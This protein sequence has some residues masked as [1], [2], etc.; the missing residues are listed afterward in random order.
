MTITDVAAVLAVGWLLLLTAYLLHAVAGDAIGR[1]ACRLDVHAMGPRR[2]P[3]LRAYLV[4]CRRGCGHLS[5]RRDRR[6]A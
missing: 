6:A 1:L 5:V 2:I 4:A 3:G